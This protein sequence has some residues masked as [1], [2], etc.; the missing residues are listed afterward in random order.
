[1][2][3]WKKKTAWFLTSQGITLFGSSLVQ[4]AMIWFVTKETSS[5][6]WVSALTVCA[7]I[8]QMLISFI[9]GAWADRHPKRNII[10]AAD[11][12]IAVATLILAILIPFISH[13]TTLLIALLV[14]SVI[15]SLGAG[16]QQPAVNALI[17]ELV[18]QEK[19]MRVNGINAMVQ[20][21]V[22]FAAPAIAGALLTFGPMRSTL[23][24]DV[25]TA[26]VGISV[27][28]FAAIPAVK[29]DKERDG[30]GAFDDVKEGARYI[31]SNGFLGKLLVVYGVFIFLCVPAGFL[32]S[33]FVSRTYGDS[34]VKMS[35]V[36]IIGFLGMLL[37]GLLMS[38]WGGFKNRVKTFLFGMTAFG[39]LAIGMGAIEIFAV[40][41]VMM[42]VYGIAL[43][44]VQTAVTTL[45]QE[46]AALEVQGRV[47]G[48]LG[49]VYSGCLP[50]GMI[51]F[52]PLAD[53]VSM[54]ILMIASGAVLMIMALVLKLNNK[55]YEKGQAVK[56]VQ[57]NEE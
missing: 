10:I 32:A 43:T 29:S 17:P 57:E 48:F 41:L 36:E 45:I 50:L 53:V 39:L 42:G 35:I 33:L 8:P 40:Y 56:P 22:Q 37:G 28:L 38:A 18:P 44:M 1:M 51:V 54:R 34:Y 25:A 12:A 24:I 13:N 31:R 21:V 20:S 47:F 15:R 23:F 55:F 30:K 11:S 52:G 26:V 16:I 4:F 14:T 9:S 3:A 49:S 19:L 27:L 7:F 5:G 46:Q 6:L 2:E